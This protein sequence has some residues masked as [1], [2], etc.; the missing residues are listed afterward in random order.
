MNTHQ[1]IGLIISTVVLLIALLFAVRF[2][3]INDHEPDV[4][5]AHEDGNKESV[6][7]KLQTPVDKQKVPVTAEKNTFQ[8]K[9]DQFIWDGLDFKLGKTKTEIIRNLGT[10]KSFKVRKIENQ[11][12]PEQID[13]IYELYFDG[14]YVGIYKVTKDGKEI[15]LAITVTSDKYK[16]KLGLNV[17]SS[18]E[19][20]VKI[21]GEPQDKDGENVYIYE[22]SI[23]FSYV[24]FHFEEGILQKVNWVFYCN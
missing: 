13:E 14:L 16:V 5:R 11:Y 4:S 18:K 22:D 12:D 3:V 2:I 15:F 24:Y 19:N 23:G 9:I 21:L 8:S 1:K 7:R 10:P 6:P 17:G 20:V